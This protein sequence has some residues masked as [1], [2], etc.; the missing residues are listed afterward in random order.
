MSKVRVRK[1]KPRDLGLFRKLWQKFMEDNYELGHLVLP[2]KQNL[3][4]ACIYFDK[5]VSGEAEGI[6]LF[7]ANDAVLMWGDDLSPIETRLEKPAQGWGVYV[8][9]QRR[10]QG[11][12]M[13][14]R[15]EGKKMLIEMGFTHVT[16]S[17]TLQNNPSYDSSVKLGFVDQPIRF[18]IME[19]TKE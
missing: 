4:V 7:V 3:D 2:S 11:V 1:A 8:A 15:E 10:R 14:M 16:G 6:V 18:G 12:S 13:I 17:T 5:Y 9:P 19:L